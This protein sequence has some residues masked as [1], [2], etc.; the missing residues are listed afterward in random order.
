M[1][2]TIYDYFEFQPA[3]IINSCP[4]DTIVAKQL[5]ILEG[6]QTHLLDSS[7]TIVPIRYL[8]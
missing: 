3:S 5:S 6:K 4:F 2:C 1:D 8:V 7:P